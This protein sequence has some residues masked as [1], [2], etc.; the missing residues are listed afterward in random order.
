[1]NFNRIANIYIYIQR[2]INRIRK[3]QR[4]PKRKIERILRLLLR[5]GGIQSTKR[6]SFIE[7]RCRGRTERKDEAGFFTRL[8]SL[9]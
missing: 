4:D 1:M 7:N 3:M 6:S 8:S 9:E 2:K 5:H